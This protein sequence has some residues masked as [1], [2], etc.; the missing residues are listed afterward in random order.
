MEDSF[1]QA[2]DRQRSVGEVP[3]RQEA[4]ADVDV[5]DISIQLS[6][7]KDQPIQDTSGRP[8]EKERR[9]ISLNDSFVS[10]TSKLEAKQHKP[11]YNSE[12]DE[13]EEESEPATAEPMRS[14]NEE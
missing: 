7:Q 12:G 3:G 6:E 14:P 8:A 4:G 5:N 10:R 1:A 9:D 13:L 11:N 2:I